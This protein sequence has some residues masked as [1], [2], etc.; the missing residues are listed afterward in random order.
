MADFAAPRKMLNEAEQKK[1]NDSLLRMAGN[2]RADEVKRLIS[3]GASVDANDGYGNTPLH[4]AAMHGHIAVVKLLLQE[5]AAEVNFKNI[6]GY[7]PLHLAALIGHLEEVQVLLEHS[8]DANLKN[9]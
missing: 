4:K 5:Y 3:E 9:A 8:A 6:D 2:G 7:T 1:M